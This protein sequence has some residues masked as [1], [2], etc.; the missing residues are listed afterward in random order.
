ML[1][2]ITKDFGSHYCKNFNLEEENLRLSK[3]SGK[4]HI[5]NNSGWVAFKAAGNCTGEGTYSDPYVIEDL[6]INGTSLGTCIWIEDSDVYFRIENCTVYNSGSNEAGITMDNV[7]CGTVS[8]NFVKNNEEGI[9]LSNSDNNTIFGNTLNNN[10]KGINSKNGDFNT[11]SGN[12]INFN[13]VSGLY[14]S[15]GIRIEDNSFNN[16]VSNN[17]INIIKDGDEAGVGIFITDCAKFKI[18]ENTFY[19]NTA[20]SASNLSNS[21]LVNNDCYPYLFGIWMRDSDNNIISGNVARDTWGEGIVM[22]DCNNNIVSGNTL[23]NNYG[24]GIYLNTDCNNNT[25]SGNTV[26]S[27]FYGIYLNINCFN[28]TISGNIAQYNFHGIYLMSSW[29]NDILRNTANSSSFG[30][31]IHL[32]ISHYNNISGNTA[33]SN[34][35]GIHLDRSHNNTVSGNTLL[36]NEECIVE[37]DCQ[38]NEFSNNGACNYG[39]GGTSEPGI[40]GYNIFFLLGIIS[41]TLLYINSKLTK[42]QKKVK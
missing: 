4:I 39:E 6:V 13:E 29:N 38:D 1:P 17:N 26:N 31:G 12:N 33:N 27:N 2:I 19:T 23:T 22:A 25:I 7:S 21:Q 14:P 36:G 10:V 32:E 5:K 34:V 9:S 11:I 42:K 41:A 24:Y 18:S 8:G 3:I 15:H 37:L 30:N 28:N 35:N 16:T 40:S 20:I